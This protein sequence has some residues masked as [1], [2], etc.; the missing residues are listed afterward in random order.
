M[1]RIPTDIKRPGEPGNV[2]FNLYSSGN[3]G[4][5]DSPF[6][7]QP[8]TRFYYDF[9]V[10]SDESELINV[11]VGARTESIIEQPL[12]MLE[13]MEGSTPISNVKEYKCCWCGGK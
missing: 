9:V 2:V 1:S 4:G 12:K 6:S 3:F 5:L 8:T 13:I 7:S 11:S 10:N